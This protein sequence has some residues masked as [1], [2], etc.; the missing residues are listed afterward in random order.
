MAI[1]YHYCSPQAFLQIIERKC[2]WLSST[3]N[4]NDFS[5]G[6]WFSKALRMVLAEKEMV[7]GEQWCEAV[8]RYFVENLTPKYITCFSKNNDSLSQWRAYA[9]DG[10]GVSIGFDEEFLGAKGKFINP[11]SDIEKSLCLCDVNYLSHHE[12]KGTLIKQA[13]EILEE[14]KDNPN[15]QEGVEW[16]AD[17][18]VSLAMEVKNPAFEE[19]CEKR[20]VYSADIKASSEGLLEV[21]NPIGEMRHR[22]SNG[23]LTSY[24]EFGLLVQDAIK[25]ITLGPKNKFH[26]IDIQNF[27]GLNSLSHIHVKRSSATYR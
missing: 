5:E 20:L 11:H 12:I 4:M 9:Q 24:F 23:Y 6:E 26:N 15:K 3:N 1:I 27:L 7:Y 21:K 13:N 25:E 18:C 19:E 14:E 22:I 17:L 8:W 2:I 16:F 10:E